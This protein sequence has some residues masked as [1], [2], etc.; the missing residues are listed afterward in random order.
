MNRT[1]ILLLSF[2]LLASAGYAL[3]NRL[4]ISSNINTGIRVLIDG[5]PYQLDN[6]R[7]DGEISLTDLRPGNRNMKIY[8]QTNAGRTRQGNT[9]SAGP[10][11]QLIYNGNLYM[12]NG[13]DVDVSINRFG[14]VFVDEQ[15]INRGYGNNDRYEDPYGGGDWNRGNQS[16]NENS[17]LQLKQ[18][19]ARERFEDTRVSIAKNGVNSYISSSQVKDLMGLFNFENNKLELAK[20]FYRFAT[21]KQYYYSVADVLIH[22][23]SKNEL[24]RL[25][26]QQK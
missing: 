22:S 13:M 11:M 17:F 20:Y 15:A 2:L 26:Q 4:T 8:I 9:R 24:M 16:M 3:E 12:R 18:A 21:D 7:N 19:L 10:A 23:N 1:F 25:I 6:S 5:R 14:K